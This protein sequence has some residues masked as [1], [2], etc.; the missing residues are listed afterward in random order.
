[1][2]S[3]EVMREEELREKVYR[4]TVSKFPGPRPRGITSEII[5][6]IIDE[7][8]ALAA[9]WEEVSYP[10]CTCGHLDSQHFTWGECVGD[11]KCP[12]NKFIPAVDQRE[13]AM[14]LDSDLDTILFDVYASAPQHPGTVPYPNFAPYRKRI[15]KVFERENIRV[16]QECVDRAMKQFGYAGHD[17]RRG[18]CG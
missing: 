5:H 10:L 4:S 6:Y 2:R 7:I 16:T 15:K 1:M 18:N 14:S 17:R 8:F 9:G 13:E 3:E 11:D 12:C